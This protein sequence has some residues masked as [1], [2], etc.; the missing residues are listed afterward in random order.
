MDE[1]NTEAV[2]NKAAD[3]QWKYKKEA[4]DDS[5]TENSQSNLVAVEEPRFEAVSWTASEYIA[6]EKGANWYLLLGAGS[7]VIVAVAY[8]LT[9]DIFTAITVV[10]ACILLGIYAGRKP[11]TKKY[12][13]DQSGIKIGDK[14]HSFALFKSF[15]VVEEGSID[16]IW[17]KPLKRFAPP[18]VMYFPP[19]QGEQII[20][21]ISNYLPHEDRE[22]DAI[23]R[24]SKRMRF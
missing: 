8:F 11:Q 12:A 3:A 22:L 6:H 13:L 9:Q 19:D 18:I 21:V 2:A 23:D 10:I 20:D 5:Y 4:S 1:Q 14:N 17:L 24:A 7:I 15:S 16:S